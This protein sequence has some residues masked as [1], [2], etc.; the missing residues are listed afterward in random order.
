MPP[1]GGHARQPRSTSM[2]TDKHNAAGNIL[3]GDE[4]TASTCPILN[5]WGGWTATAG[6]DLNWLPVLCLFAAYSGLAEPSVWNGVGCSGVV[7]I[8]QRL[9]PSQRNMLWPQ[10]PRIAGA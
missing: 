5:R 4:T 2:G 9:Q 6:S 8:H 7:T 3:P 10:P 1:T